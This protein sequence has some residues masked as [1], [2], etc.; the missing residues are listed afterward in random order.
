M[1]KVFFISFIL[2][3]IDQ[4]IKLLINSFMIYNSSIEIVKNFFYLSYVRNEGAAWSILSGNRILLI[5][6]AILAL[7]FI[8]YTLLKDKKLTKLDI[9]TYSLLIGGIIGNLLDRIIHGYVIDYLNFYIFNYNFPV[10]NFADMLIV[11]SAVLIAISILK[12]KK[13][14]V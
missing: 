5:I 2:I 12:E 3:V 6:V 13:H 14:E 8:Y 11:I 10:F 9:V 1:K 7:I 4:I